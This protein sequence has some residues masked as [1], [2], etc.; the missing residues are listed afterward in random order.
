MTDVTQMEIEAAKK[1]IRFADQYRIPAAET[2]QTI[3]RLNALLLKQAG[4]Q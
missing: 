1:L 2:Q 3:D 4:G